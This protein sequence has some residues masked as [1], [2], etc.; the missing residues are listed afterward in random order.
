[1]YQKPSSQPRSH[2]EAPL[3]APAVKEFV[4]PA[5]SNTLPLHQPAVSILAL[6]LHLTA[7]T[8]KGRAGRVAISQRIQSRR[9]GTLLTLHLVA[10]IPVLYYINFADVETQTSRWTGILAIVMY[11]FGYLITSLQNSV[12]AMRESVDTTMIQLVNPT[13]L[14]AAVLPILLPLRR[15]PSD[16]L[17]KILSILLTS[18]FPC[19][20]S[21]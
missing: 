19:V 18:S 15:V 10:R 7:G 16:M 8:C 13:L 2:P 21:C 12:L 3:S 6:Q 4:E 1:M 14:L 9:N 17:S 5:S 11:S 20:R